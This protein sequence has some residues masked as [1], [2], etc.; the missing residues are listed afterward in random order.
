MEGQSG[1]KD[2]TPDKGK[3]KAVHIVNIHDSDN[4]EGLSSDEDTEKESCGSTKKI[5]ITQSAVHDEYSRSS[6]KKKDG[7]GNL[8]S[9]CNHCSKSYIG[10]NP[11]TLK[12]HLK[13]IHPTIYSQVESRDEEKRV[14]QEDKKKSESSKSSSGLKTA[15]TSLFGPMD[16]LLGRNPNI[17][18][19]PKATQD[20]L[21]RRL[22]FW[23][24]SSTL[25]V[26]FV[27]EPAFKVFVSGLNSQ[28]CKCI[29][30]TMYCVSCKV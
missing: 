7:N 24:G 20:N 11:T 4:N 21:D 25:P 16:K 23:V 22:G 8:I 12:K 29:Y 30:N 19:L 10:I 3:R 27:E 13:N 14:A 6:E 18:A 5:R 9:K 15:A 26:S 17:P 28:A 2:K 1:V